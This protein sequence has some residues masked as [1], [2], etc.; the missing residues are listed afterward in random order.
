M[1]RR[2]LRARGYLSGIGIGILAITITAGPAMAAVPAPAAMAAVPAPAAKAAVPA[3][4]AATAGSALYSQSFA[5]D[6]AG[7]GTWIVG[8]GRGSAMPCLTAGGRSDSGDIPSCH[9]KNADS[10]GRGVLRLTGNSRGQSGFVLYTKPVNATKGLYISFDM[11]QY[12]TT[13]PRGGADGIGFVLINGAASPARAGDPGGWLGYRGLDGAYLGVGFDEW[14]NFSN[15]A[16][17]GSGPN[18]LVPDSVVIRGARS[19]RYPYIVGV[20]T[21]KMAVDG[22]RNRSRA[23]RHVVIKISTSGVM[24]IAMDF[25]HGLT[26][27]IRNLDLEHVPRQPSLP[28]TIKFGFTAAT[29]YD[30]AIHEI[31]HL[32]IRGLDP[33]LLTKIRPQGRFR[34]GGT[35]IFTATVSSATS[36][37]PTA[38][39]VTALIDVPRS[40]TPEQA[41]GKDWTCSVAG[42]QV[43]CSTNDALRPGGRFPPISVTTAIAHDAPSKLTEKSSAD[44]PDMFR[45]PGNR[46]QTTVPILPAPPGPDLSITISPVGELVAGGAGRLRLDV[47][48]AKN[49]G[50][51]TGPVDLTYHVPADSVVVSAQGTGWTCGIAI[52]AVNCDRPDVLPGGDSFPPVF[53][54]H[55]LCHKADCHLT[56]VTADVSTPGARPATV[57]PVDLTVTQRSSLGLSLSS[58]PQVPEPGYDATFTAVVTNGGPTDVE[59]AELTVTVPKGFTGAWSCVATSG[60]GCP[61]TLGS[62]PLTAELYVASGGTVTLTA[63]GQAEGTS[64]A[65]VPVSATLFP[66]SSYI[67]M[68]CGKNA[69]CTAT[70]DG[71]AGDA[72]K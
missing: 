57:G 53:L 17:W 36:G 13:T 49:S 69:P 8:A 9:W 37:G 29:G 62:G 68:Y 39:A 51:T 2:C 1:R 28:P 59:N 45:S 48:N 65:E 63:T 27:E 41:K 18:R 10:R 71:T 32:V 14:G 16:L 70:G 66:P 25:G 24:T 42:R 58:N 23:R 56:G 64:A 38:G 54:D 72:A 12:D 31:S 34:A 40:L 30:T 67:D 43:S 60:S 46:S 3:T 22:S 19:A 20:H 50:P 26:R 33:D 35:G 7:S 44:T 15:R 11:Y 55:E 6:S 21:P 4:A 5:G 61:G 47:S 52:T